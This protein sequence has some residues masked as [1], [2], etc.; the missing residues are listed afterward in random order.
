[1]KPTKPAF[2]K[3]LAQ[4]QEQRQLFV[5]ADVS[6]SD[7]VHDC[8]ERINKCVRWGLSGP[9]LTAPVFAKLS[10]SLDL[11]SDVWRQVVDTNLSG[12]FYCSQTAVRSVLAS[13]S[14]IVNVSSVAGLIGIGSR[15]AILPQS[16]AS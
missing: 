15:P 5:P 8:F 6:D 7:E 4:F 9:W 2:G 13:G 10:S 12:T 11:P 3:A 1:M 16:M 14:S